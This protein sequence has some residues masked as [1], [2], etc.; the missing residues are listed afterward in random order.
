VRN[1]ADRRLRKAIKKLESLKIL[2]IEL[3]DGSIGSLSSNGRSGNQA[4]EVEERNNLGSLSSTDPARSGSPGD[5]A[6]SAGSCT[7]LNHSSREG[8]SCSVVSE[9]SPA[10]HCMDLRDTN[11][12]CS[13]E[14]SA[15]DHD[16]DRCA[17][18]LTDCQQIIYPFSFKNNNLSVKKKSKL[19]VSLH[20]YLPIFLN[21]VF[22]Y[23][24]SLRF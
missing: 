11:N 23:F 13:S 9:Q 19:H 14:A 18:R 20:C 24:S 10:G 17:C 8:S 1:N 6:S 7:L 12:N 3:S 2:D 21:L 15:D 22:F 16:S 5:G 4:P